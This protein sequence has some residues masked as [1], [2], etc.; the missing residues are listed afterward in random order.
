MPV[1]SSDEVINNSGKAATYLFI[2][3][4]VSSHSLIKALDFSLSA[5]VI[6]TAQD[7]ADSSRSVMICW[8]EVAIPRRL[9]MSKNTLFN[10]GLPARYLRVKFVQALI[11]VFGAEA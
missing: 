1:P 7:T 11:S 9:S 2:L 6:T 8:S 4:L 3:S 10:E 5:L